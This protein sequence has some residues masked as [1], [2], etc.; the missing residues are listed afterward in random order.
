MII[1]IIVIYNEYISDIIEKIHDIDY[2]ERLI[3]VDNSDCSDYIKVNE[4]YK[5]ERIVY[6]SK[7]RNIGLSKAYNLALDYIE[8]EIGFNDN[9]WIMISDDDTDFSVEYLN[10]VKNTIKITDSNIV[11]GLIVDQDGNP[12]S[13]TKRTKNIF[14]TEYI[15]NCG[16]YSDI[17]L[18]NSGCIVKSTI[19]RNLRYDEDLFLDM[20]DYKFMYDL[21]KKQLGKIEIIEGSIVQ[22]FSGTQKSSLSAKKRRFR[23]YKNDYL[24]YAN[25]TGINSITANL[26]LLKKYLFIYIKQ[27]L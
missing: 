10:N 24:V 2:Y 11:S 23:I 15:K 17:D 9:L 12:L 3:I 8:K 6:L 20:I 1:D 22:K 7:K 14:Q 18:I 13:P 16:K 21:T 26:Y 25:K 27:F 4:E 19:F 5:S